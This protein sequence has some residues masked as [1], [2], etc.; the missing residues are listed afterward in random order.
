MV[1]K[2]NQFD[3]LDRKILKELQRD[4]SLTNQALADRVHAS[5]P[6]CQRRVQRLRAIGAIDKFVAILNPVAVGEPLIA[7]VEV[8]MTNQSAE[9]LNDFERETIRQVQVQ[10]CYQVSTGPDFILIL[11]IQDMQQYYAF[12][13]D[14]FTSKKSVRNVRAFFSIRRSK[15][16]TMIPVNE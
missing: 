16:E 15:F 1:A 3:H 9:T 6:T 10:Q 4:A 11:A 14:H 7:I 8:T 13:T 2:S 12:A 5:G